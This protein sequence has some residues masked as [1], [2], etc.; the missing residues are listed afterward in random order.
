MGDACPHAHGIHE[1]RGTTD[2]IW[3]I[4]YQLRADRAGPEAY[5]EPGLLIEPA[6]TTYIECTEVPDNDPR[7][8]LRAIPRPPGLNPPGGP[9]PGADD[10][11][12][13]AGAGQ[14]DHPGGEESSDSDS[15]SE[16]SS[17]DSE[18]LS[19]SSASADGPFIAG[20]SYF[21]ST[22]QPE[23]EPLGAPSAHPK[24]KPK[25]RPPPL[26]TLPAQVF[27]PREAAAAAAAASSSSGFSP[28]SS[29][30]MTVS[31]S[32]MPLTSRAPRMPD[33]SPQSQDAD[34][35]ADNPVGDPPCGCSCVCCHPNGAHR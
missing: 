20:G 14:G 7:R 4:W 22:A 27:L 35:T 6:R 18:R 24:P 15:D 31:S 34:A 23:E 25:R 26:P 32:G 5:N 8:A 29:S 11:G 28:S 30:G 13:H 19:L 10:P 2:D 1:Y 21:V 17:S 9:P 3:G 12:A 16:R 33:E